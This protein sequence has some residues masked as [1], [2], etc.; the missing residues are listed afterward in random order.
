MKRCGGTG[1]SEMGH[2]N[3]SGMRRSIVATLAL[4]ALLVTAAPV[5]ADS[6]DPQEAGHPVRIIAY[7]VHPVGVILDLLIFR[8]MHWIGSREPLATF[9]GHEPYDD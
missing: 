6:Y 3:R 5:A 7:A 8:P 2:C 4:G 9:F 1:G